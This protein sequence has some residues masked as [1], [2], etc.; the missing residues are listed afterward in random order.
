MLVFSRIPI[1]YLW[2]YDLKNLDWVIIPSKGL[3]GCVGFATEGRQGT[4]FQEG[5]ILQ[6]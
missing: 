1:T 4:V 3:R 5:G 2:I 6:D